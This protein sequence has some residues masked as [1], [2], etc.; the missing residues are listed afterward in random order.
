MC[1]VGATSHASFP[2]LSNGNVDVD[3]C[4]TPGTNR[5]YIDILQPSLN[6]NHWRRLNSEGCA[7]PICNHIFSVRESVWP[8]R[9][10][11]N[12]YPAE[13]TEWSIV[14]HQLMFWIKIYLELTI[15]PCL[16]LI[17]QY[18]QLVYQLALLAL[19]QTAQSNSKSLC[20][21]SCC[22]C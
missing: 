21:G 6:G 20:A 19:S 17:E 14:V 8:S 2:P 16:P 15:G 10:L 11:R 18:T 12:R 22:N 7:F 1:S 9:E 5:T 13:Y 4:T 3:V